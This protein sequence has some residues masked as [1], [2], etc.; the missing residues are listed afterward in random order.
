MGRGKGIKGACS[1]NNNKRSPSHCCTLLCF[2]PL[3]LATFYIVANDVE[4]VKRMKERKNSHFVVVL[5]CIPCCRSIK[6]DVC[7]KRVSCTVSGLGN[8]Q[9]EL[10]SRRKR[11]KK[12]VTSRQKAHTRLIRSCV[13][14]RTLRQEKINNKITNRHRVR[15]CYCPC[16]TPSWQHTQQDA[17]E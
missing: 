14:K 11:R 8:E 15:A 16:D 6:V 7:D 4:K 10:R 3:W 12:P 1:N 13:S 5:F 2:G 9:N 17:M